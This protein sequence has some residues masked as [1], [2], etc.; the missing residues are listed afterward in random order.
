MPRLVE[1]VRS[2]WPAGHTVACIGVAAPGPVDPVAGVVLRAPSL[3]GWENLPLRAIL[4]NA[5][6]TPVYVANDANVAALGEWV[7]GAGQGHQDLIY[8]TISTGI[9]GGIIVNGQLL[10]GANGLAGEVGHVTV[11][12]DGPICSC[13]RRG[14]LEALASGPSIA[15]WVQEQLQSGAPSIL[16]QEMPLSAMQIA[17]AAVEGDHLALAA[18]ERAGTYLGEALANL[19]NIFNPSAVILGGG[20]SCSGELLLT[21]IRKVLQR[22]VYS[23]QFLEKLKLT[24]AAL[25][26]EAGLLGALA[27]AQ[28]LAEKSS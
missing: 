10:L 3:P 23:Y 18:F 2:V 20:V 28:G 25:G 15:G 24:V 11:L 26:D 21:P 1:L 14:H 4:S 17:N 5:L 12:P 7:Y 22:Q 16:P 6:Q 8:L 13:G 9:G 27:L 19:I